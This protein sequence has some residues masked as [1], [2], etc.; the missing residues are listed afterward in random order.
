MNAFEK[1]WENVGYFEFKKNE[2]DLDPVELSRL[3]WN[4]AKEEVYNQLK[5]RIYKG[6]VLSGIGEYI[7]ADDIEYIKDV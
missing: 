4:A 5:E 7:D 6:G 2:L 1:W 3:S